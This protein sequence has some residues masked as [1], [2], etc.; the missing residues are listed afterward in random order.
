MQ[1]RL[2]RC[3]INGRSKLVVMAKHSPPSQRYL[4][5]SIKFYGGILV[6]FPNISNTRKSGSTHHSSGRTSLLITFWEMKNR[7]FTDPVAGARSSEVPSQGNSPARRS[8]R[9][10]IFLWR[11]LRV[12]SS[13]FC[14]DVF[15]E[16]RSG[17]KR[18]LTAQANEQQPRIDGGRR[19]QT[20]RQMYKE[21][22]V[23]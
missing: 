23:S 20:R 13:T 4:R 15:D 12:L 18:E 14:V 5:T 9:A 6:G 10:L 22:S 8:R 17:Q 21:R 19:V 11:H 2:S 1:K 3:R 7:C 16:R